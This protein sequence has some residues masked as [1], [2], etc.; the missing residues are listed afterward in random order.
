M[1]KELLETITKMEEEGHDFKS[2]PAIF[3]WSYEERPDISFEL[4][5]EKEAFD[6]SIAPSDTTIMH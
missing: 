2:V 3:K 4:L 5:I 1:K 6:A